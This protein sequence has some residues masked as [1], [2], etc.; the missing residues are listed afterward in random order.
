MKTY[1]I[2]EK[3]KNGRFTETVRYFINSEN[4]E[5]DIRTNAINRYSLN[6]S[7]IEY[8]NSL[9]TIYFSDDD[10]KVNID[11]FDFIV[12]VIDVHKKINHRDFIIKNS[13]ENKIYLRPFAMI[14]NAFSKEK[15]KNVMHIEFEGCN[16]FYLS[17]K[18]FNWETYTKECFFKSV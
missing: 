3:Y 10:L 16:I 17:Q 11:D 6:D 2:T 15:P 14:H 8:L 1:F 18:T 9:K 4:I 5:N 13:I 12:E 7:E